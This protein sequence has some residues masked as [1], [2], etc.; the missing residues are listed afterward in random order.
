M[1]CFRLLEIR[2][3]INLR[4]LRIHVSSTTVIADNELD[5]LSQLRRLNVLGIDA[6]DCRNNNVLEM[7]ERVTPP[8]SHQELY[9]RNYKKETLPSWVNPGQISRLQYLCIE[10][11]DLVKL[12]SGQTTWNLEGLC[13][14]YLMRLEVDWKDLEKDMPVLH[15]MEVSHCYKL[16]DFPCSVMEPGVWRKN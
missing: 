16:K 13:L 7:I 11:G 8:P 4:V 6:E 2:E 14:K 3:L 1:P 5:V 12:S 10:N 9:L 15:Y